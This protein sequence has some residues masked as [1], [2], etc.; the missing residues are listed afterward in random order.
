[1]EMAHLTKWLKRE[2]ANL[3]QWRERSIRL[4]NL[5]SNSMAG[6]ESVVLS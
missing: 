1:M 5:S 6:I 2:A 4:E 3:T